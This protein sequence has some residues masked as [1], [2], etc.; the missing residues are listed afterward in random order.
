VRFV[1]RGLIFRLGDHYS[2]EYSHAQSP[3]LLDKGKFLRVFFSTRRLD[4]AGV[5]VSEV[6]FVD[7]DREFKRVLAVS[8]EPVLQRGDLGQFDEH[9]IFPFH[10]RN[11]DGIN[12][13]FTTGWSRRQ[14]VDVE[15][16]IGLVVGDESGSVWSRQELGGPILSASVCEPFLVGDGFVVDT[17]KSNGYFNMYYI[18]GVKWIRE[19]HEEGKLERVY[20][21]K[22]ANS[23]NLRDWTPWNRNLI[24]D[25]LGENECQ[26]L[27]SVIF[28]DE[29][30]AMVF[31]YRNAF[32][33][34]TNVELGYRLGFA[35]S[36]NGL[37]WKRNDAQLFISPHESGWDSLMRCYPHIFNSDNG[38]CLL[39]NGDAFGKE[40][41]GLAV[42]ED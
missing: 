9:G 8:R 41:F 21:I 10:P 35:T 14:S 17:R 12:L 34:R 11:F 16:S 30:F 15:T 37:D 24:D 5:P 18:A 38:V 32:G 25:V 1:N 31:C 13:G 26:A 39:Y 3:Q 22:G 4:E 28:H 33:F 19:T 7:F 6:H 2:S 27:P 29:Q 42:Q 23:L 40:G 36:I 20:K